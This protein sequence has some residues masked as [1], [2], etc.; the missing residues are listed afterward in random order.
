MRRS[1]K[2]MLVAAATAALALPAGAAAAA[3]EPPPPSSRIIGGTNA[4]QTYSFMVSLQ[5]TGGGH[6]CGGTLVRPDWVVTASHCMAG[7]STSSFQARIGSTRTGSGGTVARPRRFE[8]HPTADLAVIQLTAP[9]SQQPIPVAAT[10]PVGTPIRILGWGCTVDPGCRDAP[11]ILQQLDT[12]ILPDSACGGSSTVI[13]VNNPGGNRGACYGDSGGPAVRGVT[14][15][16]QLVGAT[17]G[18]WGICGENPSFYTD[19]AALRGWI[20]ARTGP[21]GQPGRT[22]LAV[23]RPAV[24]STPCAASEGPEKAFNGTWTGGLTDKFCSADGAVPTLAVDLG[25]RQPITTVVVHH[26]GAGGESTTYNTR[27]YD[28]EVSDDATNWSTAAR[29]RGN[30]ASTTTHPVSVSARHV[31][32]SISGAAQ[33]SSSVVRIYEVEVFN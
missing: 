23:N 28:I 29:I 1:I 27:D 24:G 10:A 5:Y 31:R 7:E 2:S 26:A 18:G 11:E 19:T 17:S 30:T 22:N 32:L 15:S 6:F 9:V 13:C 20:E 21:T 3:D 14:G 8:N 12:S 16:F 33:D 25:S 4:D